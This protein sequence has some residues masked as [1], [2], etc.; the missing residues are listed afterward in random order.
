MRQVNVAQRCANVFAVVRNCAFVAVVDAVR[1]SRILHTHITGT[2]S[3]SSW[4]KYPEIYSESESGGSGWLRSFGLQMQP[5]MQ[6]VPR[7]VQPD[8]SR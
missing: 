3:K 2:T 6:P 4:G 7:P 1:L 5:V 8:R